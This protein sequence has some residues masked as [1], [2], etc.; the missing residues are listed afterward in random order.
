MQLKPIL[1]V[2]CAAIPFAAAAH[3]D[4][5]VRAKKITSKA[6]MSAMARVKDE[7]ARRVAV[8]KVTAGSLIVRGGLEVEEGC[9]VYAYDLKLPGN[10]GYQEV[11]VDAGTGA[12]LKVENGSAA[13]ERAEQ[14]EDEVKGIARSIEKEAVKAEGEVTGGARGTDK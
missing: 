10:G 8:D 6:D 12:V 1:A 5:S 2:L 14:A 4:C 11:I 13:R 7:A 9:L 3:L